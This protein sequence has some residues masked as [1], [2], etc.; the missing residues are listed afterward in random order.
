MAKVQIFAEGKAD[1]K[2]L[3]D[4]IRHQF[5]SDDIAH[6]VDTDGKDNLYLEVP[7]FNEN[8]DQGGINLVIF[9]ADNDYKKRK[10]ELL[11]KKK[12]LNI[13]FELFLFP[14]DSGNGALENLLEQLINPDYSEIFD[15]FE[16]YQEC[17]KGNKRFKVPALKT[18]IYAYVD[19]LLEK[20]NEKLAQEANR[21][22]TNPD[23]WNL[24]HEA[25][26]PLKGFLSTYL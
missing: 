4:L 16:T 7:K 23:H 10:A 14:N 11:S 15:C 17:L 8:S 12:E 26:D 1:I 25:L 20:K 19:T 2:F 3:K 9:D 5:G 22:Y 13:E 6:F 18:K 24:D 21:D